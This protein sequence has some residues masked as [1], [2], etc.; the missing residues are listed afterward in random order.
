[1]IIF[2][3]AL[4]AAAFKAFIRLNALELDV[5]VGLHSSAGLKDLFHDGLGIRVIG[6]LHVHLL[7]HV[8]YGT[9]LNAFHLLGSVFHFKGAGCA[10]YFNLVSFFHNLPSSLK[11]ITIKRL[12]N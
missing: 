7:G 5:A 6:E 9:A 10:V 3:K 2:I 8:V 11:Q 4:P 12:F 1:M